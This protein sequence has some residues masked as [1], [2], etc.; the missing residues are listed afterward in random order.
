MAKQMN[1]ATAQIKLE[2]IS[3][4]KARLV[5]DLIRNKDISD[6]INIL[7]HTHKK[8]APILLNLVNAAVANAVKNN[9]MNADKLFVS[10]LLVNEGPTLK[11]FQPRGRG[12]AFSILKRTSK[13]VIEVAERS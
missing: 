10:K 5:A 4:R 1:V 9:G 13:F 3:P 8:A 7:N 11:R 6:S 2:R 12:R